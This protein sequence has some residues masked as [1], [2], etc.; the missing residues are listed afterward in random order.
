[1][2]K[3]LSSATLILGLALITTGCAIPTDLRDDHKD[4]KDHLDNVLNS[5]QASLEVDHEN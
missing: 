4:A 5:G 3:K 2:N 1:M